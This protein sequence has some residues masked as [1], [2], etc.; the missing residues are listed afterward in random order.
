MQITETSAEGLKREFKIVIPAKDID[1]QVE[2]RLR[3]LSQTVRLPGFRPGKVPMALMRQRYQ[4]SVMGEVLERAVEDSSRQTISERGLRPALQPKVE[5]TA[6][7][8]GTD[9]EYNLAVELLPDIEPVDFAAIALERPVA[10]VAD[11]AVDE[12]LGRL[13]ESRK[14]SEPVEEVRPAA[15]GDVVVID[16]DGSVDGE[17][18][19]GM[20]GE[21][22]ELELGS[23]RFI[24]GFEYQL[25]G[26]GAGEHRTVN[27][28]F[29]EDYTEELAG[30]DAVFEVDVKALRKPVPAAIDD[31]L[32]QA[33]GAADLA[34]LKQMVRDRLAEDYKRVSRTRVKRALLDVLAEQCRFDVPA[35]MVQLE[36]DSIVRRLK[37]DAESGGE[38]AEEVAKGDE[39]LEA[40]YRPIAERRVR[41]GLLLAE[42]G[43]RNNIVVSQDEL[44]RAVF[45]EAQR[46]PGQERAVLDFF[47][48]NPQAAESLR[49][50]LFE[51]KVVDYVL[52]LATVSETEVS[53]EELFKE[54]EVDESKPAS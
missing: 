11:A 37:Q 23:G 50:P 16:F 39:A 31:A 38:A 8:E 53:R 1:S 10:E 26:A 33:F 29:P 12:T 51:E 54:D 41:L 52:E 40:E 42:V 5:V 48:G 18:R 9:L 27:V 36:Y 7:A 28:T 20:K 15:V 43:R 25:V 3:E 49:A 19:P 13:A 30:K 2:G 35:G 17:R 32:A 44:N 46:Y 21:D 24:P 6:F 34:A 47:R 4:Q 45:A 14:T 22:H